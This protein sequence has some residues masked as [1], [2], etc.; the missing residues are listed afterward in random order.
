VHGDSGGAARE[1]RVYDIADESQ[2]SFSAAPQVTGWRHRQSRR[3][4]RR[5]QGWWAGRTRS[6]DRRPS[7]HWTSGTGTLTATSLTLNLVLTVS[8]TYGGQTQN[9]N[10]TLAFSGQKI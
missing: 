2:V 5:T 6:G 4:L 9:S 7:S 1:Q 3:Q 8:Q 10:V